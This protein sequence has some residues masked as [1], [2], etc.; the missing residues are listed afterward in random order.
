MV[1]A[2]IGLLIRAEPYLA[3]QRMF[4][5][6]NLPLIAYLKLSYGNIVAGRLPLWTPELNAGHPCGRSQR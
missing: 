6:D 2:S 5:H 4:A 1:V 3:H